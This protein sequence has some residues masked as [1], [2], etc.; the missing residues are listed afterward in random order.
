MEFNFYMDKQH[1][2]NMLDL[3]RLLKTQ[4]FKTKKGVE[5]FLNNHLLGQTIP[6]F[7]KEA[8]TNEEQAQN[9]VYQA[10]ET[11]DELEADTLIYQALSL[12]ADCVEAYEHLA[13][14][15]GSVTASMLL[16]QS[17]IKAS[18]KKLGEKY[19]VENKGHFWGLHETRP[20]MR[21][22]K[23]YAETLYL[24]GQKEAALDVY[25][26]LLELNPND[27]QGIRDPAS[28]ICL[29][30]GMLD[31]YRK[32]YD[33]YKNDGT[34]FHMFNNALYLFLTHGDTEPSR[35]AL[36]KARHY[37]KHV[38]HLMNSKKPLPP[39]PE[40]YGFGDKNEAIYYC[41][42]AKPIWQSKPGAV[43]WMIREYSG[44]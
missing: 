28:I 19:F 1:E 35:A 30:L 31:Q 11:E 14:V 13:E 27:N 43:E 37:N 44:R 34:A 17:A 22:K 36:K 29:E 26:E 21:C 7:D 33:E 12:D 18:R 9:L 5:D 24:L 20:Y 25:Y 16:F 32:L 40:V 10:A 8:L 39:L 42:L 23:S 3:E 4:D 2:K 41:T 38:V 6:E 15:C